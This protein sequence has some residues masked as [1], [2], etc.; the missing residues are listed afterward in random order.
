VALPCTVAVLALVACGTPQPPAPR[1]SSRPAGAEGGLFR[2]PQPWTAT[3]RARPPPSAAR[4]S[5]PLTEA[6]GWGNE[7]V[8]QMRTTVTGREDYCFG[9]PDCDPVPVEVPVPEGGTWRARAT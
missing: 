6:G 5:S 4:R 1:T 3:S 8:L 2:G 7:N 9:G